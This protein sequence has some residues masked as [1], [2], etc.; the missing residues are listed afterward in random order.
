MRCSDMEDILNM[1]A[2]ELGSAI[3]RGE[4]SSP[5]AVARVFDAIE[6]KDKA[7]NAYITLNRDQ[8]LERAAVVQQKIERDE[9]TSPLA[10]VPVAIKDNICTK[11]IKTTCA[12]KIL[13][14]FTPPYS[15]TVTQKLE[16]AGMVICGKL[17][18]DEFA[19]ARQTKPHITGR[20]KTPLT[21]VGFRGAPLAGPRPRS[22]R[23]RRS[24]LL[25]RIPAGAYASR[26]PIVG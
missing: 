7:I 11:G 24:A 8:A 16:T 3:K 9:L 15:A 20:S 21:Q 5:E 25:A 23:V 22:P 13:G 2:L 4:I 26:P 19:W 10:G 17:N 12:S 18:M 1:T 6:T 14:D